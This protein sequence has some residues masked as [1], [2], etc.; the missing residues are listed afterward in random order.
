MNDD[1]LIDFDIQ[2]PMPFQPLQHMLV[3]LQYG[4]LL[5]SFH[6]T[7]G[8]YFN[9]ITESL[10]FILIYLGLRMVREAHPYFKSAYMLSVARLIIHIISYACLCIPH[11]SSDLF[12][13]VSF[14]LH[15]VMIIMIY[16]ALKEI[17]YDNT[18]NK[19]FIVCYVVMQVCGILGTFMTDSLEQVALIIIFIV[20]FIKMWKSLNKLKK[21][22]LD[23]QYQVKLSPIK[24]K[25]RWIFI[26]YTAIMILC[27]FITFCFTV[28]TRYEI[29][30]EEYTINNDNMTLVDELKKKETID[31]ITIQYSYQIYEKDDL[32]FHCL[33]YELLDVP[34]LTYMVKTKFLHLYS[35][36]SIEPVTYLHQWIGIDDHQHYQ[37]VEEDIYQTGW[38]GGQNWKET[39]AYVNPLDSHIKG[40]VYFVGQKD[41]LATFEFVIGLKSTFQFPYQENVDYGLRLSFS[42]FLNKDGIEVYE[43]TKFVEG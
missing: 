33:E 28:M 18:N 41:K 1:Y 29:Q 25:K 30:G 31:H 32:L 36:K 10:G 20:F 42:H 4:L 6:I 14:C 7:L 16:M 24:L 5:I 2:N 39:K 22:I 13:G 19:T 38:F 8:F 37:T 3:Y 11:Y 9:Y 23:Y 21:D 35:E 34:Q 43:T 17:V 12:V 15:F 27:L 26:G 40:A